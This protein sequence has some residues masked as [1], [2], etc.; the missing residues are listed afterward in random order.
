MKKSFIFICFL[1]VISAFGCGAQPPG[2]YWAVT[3]PANNVG[4]VIP[5][6]VDNNFSEQDKLTLSDAINQ[7]NYVLNGQI[8]LD[9]VDTHFDMEDN[10]IKEAGNKGGWLFLKI[11][12]NNPFIPS[13]GPDLVTLAFADQIGGHTIFFVQDVMG[14]NRLP[15][16]ALHEIGHLLGA[17]HD[18]SGLMFPRYSAHGFSCVDE[19]AMKEVAEFF[20]LDA[21]RMNYCV[22]L[23]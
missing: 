22:N 5:I 20:H 18:S 16:V 4:R 11:D 10:K 14:Q 19:L 13:T 1:F 12:H 7:W 23:Q 15:G 21:S 17:E 6:W 3:T 8:T 9:I 2:Y